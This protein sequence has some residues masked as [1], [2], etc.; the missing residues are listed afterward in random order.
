MAN[1]KIKTGDIVEVVAGKDKG[2]RGKVLRVLT[3]E[4]KVIV[5][6][7]NRA[8]KNQKPRFNQAG[9]QVEFDAPLHISNVMLFDETAKKRTRVGVQVTSDKRVRISKQ[10]GNEI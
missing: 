7:V 6:G 4:S 2:K 9:Q 1:T 3:G 10:T 5:E 8:K